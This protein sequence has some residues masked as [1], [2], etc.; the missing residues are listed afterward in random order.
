MPEQSIKNHNSVV[1]QSIEINSQ[2]SQSKNASRISVKNP[3]INVQ[4]SSTLIEI[5]EQD[6]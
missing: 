2:P 6:T 3:V 4:E 5:Y 1:P